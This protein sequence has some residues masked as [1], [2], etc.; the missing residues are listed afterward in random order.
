LKGDIKK[1]DALIKNRDLHH[2]DVRQQAQAIKKLDS[3]I[4]AKIVLNPKI[5]SKHQRR[6]QYSVPFSF[7][8]VSLPRSR[9]IKIPIAIFSEKSSQSFTF[10]RASISLKLTLYFYI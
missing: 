1:P 5:D 4:N 10:E 9:R 3:Y 7:F 2:I 6:M 8:G